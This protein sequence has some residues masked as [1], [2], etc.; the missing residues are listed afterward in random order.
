MKAVLFDLDGVLID[1]E[2]VI[3]VAFTLSYREIVGEKGDPPIKEYMLHMGDSFENIMEKL[4]LPKLMNRPFREYSRKLIDFIKLKPGILPL[5]NDLKNENFRL[6]V[7]TGKDRA[8]TMEI[9]EK[10]KISHFFGAVVT[11]DDTPFPKP[12]TDPLWIA[13]RELNVERSEAMM[14][15]DASNDIIASHRA[16]IQSCAVT[17]GMSDLETLL[18]EKPTYVARCADDI[19]RIVCSRA[20]QP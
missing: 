1:S 6:A 16:G 13:L 11:A 3:K 15:G 4:N 7:I 19:T 8:R 20:V 5:L 17:W 9:L 18:K 2:L 10:F 12:H 14:V